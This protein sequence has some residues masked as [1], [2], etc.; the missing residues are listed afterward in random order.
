M[1]LE[2]IDMLQTVAKRIGDEVNKVCMKNGRH[3]AESLERQ[4]C[5]AGTVLGL[6]WALSAIEEAID[7]VKRGDHMKELDDGAA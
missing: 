7:A 4:H 2:T 1:S 6:E 5:M 3:P